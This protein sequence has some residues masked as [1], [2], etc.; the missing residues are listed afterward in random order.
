MVQQWGDRIEE[1]GRA[2]NAGQSKQQGGDKE[3]RPDKQA[4]VIRLETAEDAYHALRYCNHGFVRGSRI[5]I[6]VL[7]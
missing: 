4:A 7:Q 5:S 2:Q 3:G 6:R 1:R